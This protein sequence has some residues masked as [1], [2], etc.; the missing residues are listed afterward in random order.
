MSFVSASLSVSLPNEIINIIM[1]YIQK[2]NHCKLLN[3]MICDYYEKDYDPFW[4][5]TWRGN[6]AFEYSFQEWYFMYRN[7][8]KYLFKQ[9]IFKQ[10]IF[11]QKNKYY[12]TPAQLII[13]DERLQYTTI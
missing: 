4:F 3:T 2:P 7:Q 9:K 11:K 6:Y 8:M 12:H 10:E 5:E 1:S 13:G